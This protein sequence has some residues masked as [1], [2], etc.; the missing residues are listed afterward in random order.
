MLAKLIDNVTFFFKTFD[1][2]RGYRVKQGEGKLYLS[3]EGILVSENG[4]WYNLPLE[5]IY[6]VNRIEGDRPGLEFKIPGM[7]VIVKGNNRE[8]LWAL[9][10]FLLPNVRSS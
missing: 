3:E 4:S 10:H 6:D 1:D 5:M 9:R 8:F 7:D 2:H